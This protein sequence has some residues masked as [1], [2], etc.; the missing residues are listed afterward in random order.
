MGR[1][2]TPDELYAANVDFLLLE[3]IK[4]VGISNYPLISRL[5]GLNMETIRDKIDSQLDRQALERALDY[6]RRLRSQE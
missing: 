1:E 5:T 3:T 4:R 2:P 6:N